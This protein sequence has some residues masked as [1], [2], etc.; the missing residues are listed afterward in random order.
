[1]NRINTKKNKGY[2]IL[3][4]LFYIAF[5]TMLSLVVIQSV[6]TMARSFKETAIYTELVQSGT[7]MEKMSREIRRSEDINVVSATN[8]TLSMEGGGTAELLLSD[9]DIEFYEDGT[10]VGNLNSPNIV[11]TG[12]SFTQIVTAEGKAVKTVLSLRSVNDSLARVYDFY[13]TVVLRGS[14]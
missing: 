12:L 9:G 3:E 5:L 14:Y 4:L 6:I 7:I 1:M 11:V 2:A 8:L 10:L 13:N